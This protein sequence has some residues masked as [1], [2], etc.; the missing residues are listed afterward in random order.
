MS[1]KQVQGEISGLENDLF[2]TYTALIAEIAAREA[3]KNAGIS[4]INSCRTG[5]ISATSVGGMDLTEKYFYS[6]F[7]TIPLLWLYLA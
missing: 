5:L 7:D 1:A 2:Y 3:I 6:W 4:D